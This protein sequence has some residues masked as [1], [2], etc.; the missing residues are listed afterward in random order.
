[1]RRGAAVN[2][3]FIDGIDRRDG[4]ECRDLRQGNRSLCRRHPDEIDDEGMDADVGVVGGLLEEFGFGGHRR[5]EERKGRCGVDLA[6]LGALGE[7]VPV[8][9]WRYAGRRWITG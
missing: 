4:S 5:P 9:D 2:V 6:R 8:L 7:V 1:E 3:R